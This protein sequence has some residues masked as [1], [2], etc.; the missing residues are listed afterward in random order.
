MPSCGPLAFPLRALSWLG[1]QGTRAIALVLFVAIAVPPVGE[2]TRPYVTHA[3]FLLLCISFMRVDIVLLRAH[4]R[5]PL[6]VV[7]AT[8]WTTIAVP[9]L[10]GTIARLTGFDAAAP[11]LHLALMLQATASPMMASPALAGLMGLDATLVLI[12]LV[13]ST[14]LV[15]LTAPVFAYVF[16]GQTLALSPAALGLKLAAILAGA[17]A[18]ATA[19]RL[20]FGIEAIRRHRA[21]IDGFNICILFVFASAIMAHFLSDLVTSPFRM[22]GL[23]VLAFA[24][25][26]LLLGITMLL[27]RGAGRERA[28][29]LGVMVSLR[30]MG[31]MLAA[32]EG[33]IP[34]TTWLYFA[35]SQF[36]IHLAPQL[37][38]PFA[39]RLRATPLPSGGTDHGVIS[40]ARE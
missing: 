27:F 37:L 22:L 5:R 15:P 39:E 23:A 40:P 26:F 6:L 19:V 33:A 13:T 31:L 1:N 28:M 35:M 25:F 29:A 24:V 34:G 4:L 20:A 7:A 14:A 8:A 2:L 38:R 18:A 10:V 12:T 9:A 16:L 17:V 30:N 32:T 21:P 3:I 36:P 11:E